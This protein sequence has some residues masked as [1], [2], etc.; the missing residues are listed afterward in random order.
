MTS[1]HDDCFKPGDHLMPVDQAIAILNERLRPAAAIESV[2]LDEAHGRVLARDVVSP[3]NVP[4]HDNSAVDGYALRHGD[5]PADG[6]ARLAVVGRAAAGHPFEGDIPAGGAVR[7]FTGAPMPAGLDS[8][9]MQEDVRREGAVL[10]I[11]PGLAPGANRRNCGEDVRTGDVVLGAGARLHPQHIGLAASVGMTALKVY[12]PLR[13]AIFSTGDEICDPGTPLPAGGIYD[14]NRRLLRGLVGGL[15]LAVD[16]LGILPD[17]EGAIFEALDAARRNHD[18]V[19]TSGGVSIGEEDHVK[20]VV[21]RLGALHFWRLAIKPGRPVALGQLGDTPFIGLPGNP[22]AV[23]VTFML[24]ARPMLQIL[25]G[26]PPAPPRRYRIRAGFDYAKK[27]G[28]REWLRASLHKADDGQ[29]E[30]HRHARQ[31]SG[32]L[33]AVVHSDG[34]VEVGETVTHIEQGE[35]VDFL[36]YNEVGV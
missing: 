21:E 2:A 9:V 16:D 24:L 23:M 33:S 1:R 5:L 27:P 17:R 11:P 36:P 31:G 10:I 8:V 26:E 28:R 29:W 13:V 18:V 22:V 34:L 7:I 3:R 20:A 25:G 19:I 32:V 4:P 12:A 6:E 15:G 14:S 30:A 35:L